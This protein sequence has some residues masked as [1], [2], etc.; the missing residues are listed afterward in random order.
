MPDMKVKAL[1]DTN[2]LLDFFQARVPFYADAQ[3]VWDQITNKTFDGYVTGVTIVN[4][5][6]IVEKASGIVEARKAVKATLD[7]CG[8]CFVDKSVVDTAYA[9]SITEL[10]RRCTTRSCRSKWHRYYRHAQ[11]ARLQECDPKN[12][13]TRR[14]PENTTL[15]PCEILPY[16]VYNPFV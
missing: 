5:F 14:L 16:L 3:A 9:S 8:V 4:V 13:D 15:A 2:I 10:R 1:L 12:Y 7:I 6:Y 11:C